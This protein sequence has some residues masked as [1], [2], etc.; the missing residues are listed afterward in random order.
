MIFFKYEKNVN[1]HENISFVKQLYA[2]LLNNSSG[3]IFISQPLSS[4]ATIS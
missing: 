1:S 3:I 2:V 4:L